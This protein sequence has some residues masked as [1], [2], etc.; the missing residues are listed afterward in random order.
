MCVTSNNRLTG[1][2]CSSVSLPVIVHLLYII[3]I[4]CVVY[5]HDVR[6][7]YR[8]NIYKYILFSVFIN[9]NEKNFTLTI[10]RRVVVDIIGII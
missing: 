1:A 4:M 3:Y 7:L 5:A 8:V 9:R 10:N 2:K 6:T